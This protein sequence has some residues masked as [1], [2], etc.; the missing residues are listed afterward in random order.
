MYRAF[1][2]VH[3]WLALAVSAFLLVVALSGSLL[4]FE[5][6]ARNAYATHV[7][8]RGSP[9]SLDTIAARA[10][11]AAGGA[12]VGMMGFGDGPD[13]AVDLMMVTPTDLRAQPRFLTSDPYSGAVIDQP[14][15]EPTIVRFLL[16]AHR[17]HTALLAGAA[18]RAIVTV[19]TALALLLVVSG[20]I[21][22]WR[23][24]LWT[25]NGSASWK[26]IN[27]DLHHAL[28]IFSSIVLLL[29]ASTG[30][31][32]HFGQVDDLLLRM[33]GTAAPARPEQPAAAP[34][35]VPLSLDSLV[36]VAHS[37]VP[38]AAVMNIQLPPMARVP[39]M[40]QLRYPEDHTPSG[41]S[42]VFIDKYRG[43]V[44]L[45]SNTR[46][47]KAGQHL[48]DIKR[49]LHTGDI[50]GTPTQLLWALASLVLASQAVTGVLMWWNAR[51]ARAARTDANG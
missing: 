20:V 48:V 13:Y 25:V 39:A 12:S 6:P 46:T 32:V 27:F 28:G 9:L 38:G 36:R 35:A 5:G 14:T 47:A 34:G 8:P 51:R 31:W 33:D 23:D 7:V 21:V 44:L 16:A 19:V 17:I 30:L 4:V 2:V 45:A 49:A 11:A 15:S 10:S 24:K 1:L 41:R 26:R 18:G 3:R 40:V 42:R 50:Y 22:W 29:I 43:T 37:A